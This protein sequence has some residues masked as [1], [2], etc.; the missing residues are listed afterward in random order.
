MLTAFGQTAFGQFWCFNVLAK[1]SVVVIVVLGCCCLS[2]LLLFVLGCCFSWLLLMLF[3]VVACCL[4]V[5]ACWCLLVPVGGVCW[6][7]LL[8]CSRFLGLSPDHLPLD[9]PF[10]GPPFPWTALPLD[11]P[12]F[13]SFFSLSRQK[14]RSFLPSL[15]VFSLNIGGVFED[16]GAQM[17][18]FGL[19]GCRVKPRR[20]HQTGPPCS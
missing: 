15:G 6:W 7:C 14:I 10:P 12:K 5:G 9:P 1:F 13:R 3:L 11:R 17:C 16:R 4:L 2:L 18:T 8:V 19:S 20:P